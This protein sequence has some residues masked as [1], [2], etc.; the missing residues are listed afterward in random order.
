MVV[1]G[2]GGISDERGT[3]VRFRVYGLWSMVYGF[4]LRSRPLL[5][6]RR[7]PILPACAWYLRLQGYLA[8]KKRSFTGVLRSYESRRV[9]FTI[10]PACAWYLHLQGYLGLKNPLTILP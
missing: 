5:L 9:C 10:L 2:R 8:H 3:P 7:P 4:G 6:Q 1:L